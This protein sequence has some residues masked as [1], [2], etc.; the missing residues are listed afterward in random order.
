MAAKHTVTYQ[1]FNESNLI[2]TPITEKSFKAGGISYGNIRYKY[3]SSTDSFYLMVKDVKL[4]R[5]LIDKFRSK[6]DGGYH[7]SE[8]CDQR[9][10]AIISTKELPELEKVLDSI[11]NKIKKFGIDKKNNSILEYFESEIN[12]FEYIPILKK[13][14][15]QAI[16]I[17]RDKNKDAKK[18]SV[19]E[20]RNKLG[21]K[22]KLNLKVQ[23]TTDAQNKYHKITGKDANID[24]NLYTLEG[25]ELNC[26]KKNLD[27]FEKT[28][29]RGCNI[30]INIKIAS[31]WCSPSQK[32]YGPKCI[33]NDIIVNSLATNNNDEEAIFV[34]DNGEDVFNGVTKLSINDIQTSE[35]KEIEDEIN[36]VIDNDITEPHKRKIKKQE[37]KEVKKE[38]VK[39]EEIKEEIKEDEIKEDEVEED[40]DDSIDEVQNVK[41]EPKTRTRRKKIIP[42]DD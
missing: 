38:E 36:N 10:K 9:Y 22:L 37:N 39:K 6:A 18:L 5:N 3:K 30:D 24:C 29:T 11:D 16:M 34:D 27:F 13:P 31:W 7:E 25:V 26:S 23:G 2:L 21:N 20:I 15:S 32:T 35:D 14:T 40:N 12:K 19:D 28:F 4:T 1:N 41:P 33:V 8:Y 17:Y 42:E